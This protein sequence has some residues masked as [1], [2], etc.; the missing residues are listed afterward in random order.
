MQEPR[1]GSRNFAWRITTVLGLSKATRSGTPLAISKLA[2]RL[3]IKGS[4]RRG[5]LRA[6]SLRWHLR[7]SRHQRAKASPDRLRLRGSANP[8][9]R[10]CVLR[11]ANARRTVRTEIWNCAAIARA[12]TFPSSNAWTA[13]RSS[14]LSI[15]LSSPPVVGNARPTRKLSNE[16]GRP[17]GVTEF[18]ENRFQN[19]ENSHQSIKTPAKSWIQGG[20][21]PRLTPCS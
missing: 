18:R 17:S 4:T 15:I 10:G 19:L 1:P 6:R 5:R 2:N 13:C 8:R 11:T 16:V 12:A 14:I 3:R 7:I 9:R 21:R 20:P